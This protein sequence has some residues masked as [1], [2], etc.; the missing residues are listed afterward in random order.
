MATMDQ[1]IE[2][3]YKDHWEKAKMLGCQLVLYADQWYAGDTGTDMV[4]LPG[5]DFQGFDHPEFDSGKVPVRFSATLSEYPKPQWF[6]HVAKSAL[7][8]DFVAC[9]PTTLGYNEFL[10]LLRANEDLLREVS[11]TMY[12]PMARRG[13]YTKENRT[14]A[15]FVGNPL[16]SA[17]QT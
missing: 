11:R 13:M 17:Q 10:G 2:K 5:W 15:R 1:R 12:M 7:Y 4:F 6:K 16:D 8:R 3:R 14:C 9:T